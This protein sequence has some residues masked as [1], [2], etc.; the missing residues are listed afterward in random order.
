[1]EP[2]SWML[3]Y[4]TREFSGSIACDLL[5]MCAGSFDLGPRNTEEC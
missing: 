1:M 5:E 4:Q 2:L 3:E